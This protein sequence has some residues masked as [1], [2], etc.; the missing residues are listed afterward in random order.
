MFVFICSEKYDFFRCRGPVTAT[1]D[2][3]LVSIWLT[4][5]PPMTDDSDDKWPPAEVVM[6][7]T[8]RNGRN[9]TVL[10]G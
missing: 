8:N 5:D 9:G 1:D 2:R 10:S 6:T 3:F 7:V 4:A